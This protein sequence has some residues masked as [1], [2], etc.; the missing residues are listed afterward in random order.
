MSVLVGMLIVH[1]WT[2]LKVVFSVATEQQGLVEA[3]NKLLHG[4]DFQ[5]QSIL[6][7]LDA[8]Q[9]LVAFIRFGFC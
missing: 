4:L 1:R 7:R 8:V 3:Y 5:P 9:Q 6:N 2:A